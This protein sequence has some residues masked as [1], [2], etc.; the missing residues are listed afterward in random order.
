MRVRG[1][2]EALDCARANSGKKQIMAKRI[3][4]IILLFIL[5][6]VNMFLMASIG[7]SSITLLL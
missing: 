4:K 3:P 5:V 1:A 6:W 2:E 7:N